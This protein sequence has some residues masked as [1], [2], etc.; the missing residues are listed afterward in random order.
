LLVNAT[1]VN[2]V[3]DALSEYGITHIDMP[4]TRAGLARHSGRQE[5]EGDVGLATNKGRHTRA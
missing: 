2:A 4:L 1:L 5:D 3:R